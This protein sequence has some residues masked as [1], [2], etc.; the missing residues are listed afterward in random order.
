VGNDEV[1]VLKVA[2]EAN[3]FGLVDVLQGKEDEIEDRSGQQAE[4]DHALF[5]QSEH[6][7]LPVDHTF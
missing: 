1:F 3:E 6:V 5:P 4:N 2:P 7:C